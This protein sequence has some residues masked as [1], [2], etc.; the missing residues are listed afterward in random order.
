MQ[1][2]IRNGL[3][4]HTFLCV[5]LLFKTNNAK[6]FLHVHLQVRNQFEGV[7]L[8]H[9]QNVLLSCVE[10]YFWSLL[11]LETTFRI[12]QLIKQIHHTFVNISDK[13]KWLCDPMGFWVLL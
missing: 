7:F 5:C 8:S 10:D 13:K 2:V 11:F 1:C 3:R 4:H 12:I 9:F 6:S